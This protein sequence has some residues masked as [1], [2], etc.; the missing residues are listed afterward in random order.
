MGANY[1]L[2][3]RWIST[4]IVILRYPN[5]AVCQHNFRLS[6]RASYY[7]GEDRAEKDAKEFCE[8]FKPFAETLYCGPVS[9]APADLLLLAAVAIMEHRC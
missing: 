8:T 5:G 7:L 4:W 3:D 6:E 1:I 9:D 2:K